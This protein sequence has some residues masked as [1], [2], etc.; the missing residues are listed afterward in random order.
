MKHELSIVAASVALVCS[1]SSANAQEQTASAQSAESDIEKIRI[2]GSRIKRAD[3]STPQPV[4]SFNREDIEN[5]GTGDITDALLEI[6]AIIGGVTAE[7]ATTNVQNNGLTTADLRGLGDNRTLVLIDGRRAVSSSANGNRVDLGSL[8][9]GFIDSVEVLTGGTSAVYGSD[10]VAGVVNI[11]T[12]S[13]KEGFELDILGDRSNSLSDSSQTIDFSWGGKFNDDKGYLFGAINLNTRT[14][15]RV[16][17]IP[18]TQIQADYQYDD[19]INTFV[20][21]LGNRIPFSEIEDLSTF[22]FGNLSNDIPGGRFEG[23]DFFFNENGLQR[24]FV[25]DRDGFDFRA[26]DF[27]RSQRDRVTAAIKGTYEIAESTTAFLTVN[28]SYTTTLQQRE[29][30]GD[31]FNDVHLLVTDLETFESINFPIGAIPI[32][33]PFAPQEIVDEAGSSI[34]FDRRFNEVGNQITDNERNVTRVYAGLQ[35]SVFDDWEWETVLSYGR[36]R[37]DQTRFNEINI[38][39]LR[40]GLNAEQLDD[41]TI[42]CADADDRA[43][44]CV[45]VNLFGVNSITPEAAD[46]IRANLSQEAT[47]EQIDFQAFITGDL[48]ELPAGYVGS[49]FGV[50]FRRDSQQ[51]T[52]DELNQ[53]GGHSSITVPAFGG[54]YNVAE[55]FGELSFPLLFDAPGAYNLSLDTS[56]RIA[57]YS[58]DTVGTVL[59]FGVGVQ[60]APVE[61]LNFRVSFNRAQRAPDLTELF[62]P[63]RGDSDGFTDICDGVDLN[64]TGVVA[65]NC[66]SEPGVL[67][68]IQE[69]GVFEEDSGNHPSPNAGNIN[70]REE[71]ADTLTV[72]FVWQP[73]Y[74]PGLSFSADY[75]SIEIEDA[76]DAF[77]NED[78][79]RF[80]YEDDVN[81]RNGQNSFCN[82]IFRNPDDGQLSAVIQRQ[83][84]LNSTETSGVDYQL[85]YDFDLESIGVPGSFEA[86]YVHS[87]L[88]KFVDIVD[89]TEPGEI[90]INNQKGE[91]V[92]ERFEDRGRFTFRWRYE[93]WRVSWRTTYFGSTIDSFDL[94]EDFREAQEEFGDAAETPAFLFIDRELFHNLTVSY[95]TDIGKVRT[96]FSAGVR[97]L[98]DNE[99]PFLPTGDG[100]AG[101][102]RNSANAFGIRGRSFFARVNMRF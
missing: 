38:V 77:R 47:I 72:G 93:D 51:L 8:P 99:G 86:R 98:T 7:N 25:T 39:N 90:I 61:E 95:T 52:P 41:G 40:A 66:R 27:L 96:R 1:L 34:S 80:C 23:N 30:E 26:D 21:S 14:P 85:T 88:I 67:A 20:N 97:N 31:D 50:E 16:S 64:T 89:G 5:V 44:G 69:N 12:E 79:L 37:Q 46:F 15:R 81:F 92:N 63:P 60:Y 29:P 3:F 56:A 6:P 62:S 87:H 28:H 53:R 22:D 94:L 24:D 68:A 42:Q 18:R 82:D 48:F 73:D 71:E 35:G 11:I 59:S 13:N 54:G 65:N 55:A 33:N 75:Y 58:I 91:L 36:F 19:G 57:N 9:A 74:V 10:A 43:A 102:S 70:L 100:D 4:V 78:L 84:N 83:F 32:D 17:E 101:T 76:I 49:A 2:T 45:P